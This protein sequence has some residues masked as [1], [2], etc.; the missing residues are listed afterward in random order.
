[1][2]KAPSGL[3]RPSLAHPGRVRR[4]REKL[5]W[6]GQR[7]SPDSA[8]C[9][10]A[11]GPAERRPPEV[12]SRGH[13][14]LFIPSSQP[15]GVG[16]LQPPNSYIRVPVPSGWGNPVSRGGAALWGEVGLSLPLGVRAQRSPGHTRVRPAASCTPDEPCCCP[17]Y[18]HCHNSREWPG[19]GQG[20]A[21]GHTKGETELKRQR[22][23]VCTFRGALP[24]WLDRCDVNRPARGRVATVPCSAPTDGGS[25]DGEGRAGQ[26]SSR[27]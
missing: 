16:V 11:P 1:M 4:T 12:P 15:L 3:D 20:G 18:S 9:R 14:W 13:S 10:R 24:V 19:G 7:L 26:T 22:Q 5:T 6:G 2:S 25:G 27:L 17:D 23:G 21:H 8:T